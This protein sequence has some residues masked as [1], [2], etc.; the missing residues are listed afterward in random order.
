MVRHRDQSGPARQ[1]FDNNINIRH[2]VVALEPRRPRH[3]VIVEITPRIGE[4]PKSE[5][6]RCS[7]RL[8]I[9]AA[10]QL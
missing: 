8:T 2:H 1:I 10:I 5:N 4:G 3:L 7:G 9:E 6:M